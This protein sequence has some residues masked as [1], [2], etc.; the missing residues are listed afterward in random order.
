MSHQVGYMLGIVYQLIN[1]PW[2]QQCRFQHLAS[3]NSFGMRLASLGIIFLPLSEE[4]P[5]PICGTPD[6]Y[7]SD[8]Y[9]FWKT[10]RGEPFHLHE[11]WVFMGARKLCIVKRDLTWLHL[12]YLICP[13]LWTGCP[14]HTWA[15]KH[16]DNQDRRLPGNRSLGQQYASCSHCTVGV[17]RL[18]G[19]LLPAVLK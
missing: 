18:K 3:S 1:F 10:T 9:L 8:F 2:P 17:K 7:S 16:V 15:G 12:M 4:Y 11:V 5:L 6:G 14:L 19:F 13:Q